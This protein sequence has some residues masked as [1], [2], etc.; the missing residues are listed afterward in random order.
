MMRSRRADV[1]PYVTRDG[2]LIRELMHPEVHGNGNQSL[3]EA[4]L[5][6]GGESVLH[7]HQ[8]SEEIYH[9]TAGSGEMTL[10]ED[11]FPVAAGDTVCIPPGTPHRLRNTGGED[12]VVLCACSPPYGHGDTELMV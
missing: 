8:R 10:G 4:V 3:A 9:F 1:E 11:T 7:R 5:A 6:P 2:T 12:L